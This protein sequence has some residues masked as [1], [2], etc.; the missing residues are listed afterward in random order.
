MLELVALMCRAVDLD[1]EAGSMAIEVH[2]VW[3]Q[4]M[5]APERNP[6]ELITLKQRPHHGLGW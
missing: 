6:I 5:L 3:P 4:W 2:D 1:H